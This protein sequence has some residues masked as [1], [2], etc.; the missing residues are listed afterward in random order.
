M[1]AG[2]LTVDRSFSILSKPVD[3]I[4]NVRDATQNQTRIIKTRKRVKPSE[5]IVREVIPAFAEKM[6]E[7]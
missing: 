2:T 1:T 6:G 3:S 5:L 7:P 4:S